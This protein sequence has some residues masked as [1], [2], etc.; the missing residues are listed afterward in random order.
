MQFEKSADT[1][2]IESRL[3]EAKVGDL[4]TYDELSRILGRDVREFAYGALTSARK[5][6]LASGVVFGTESKVGIKRLDDLQIINS[7]ES[8]RKRLQ[9]IGKHSLR[10]LSAVKF[11]NLTEESKR[12]HTTMAAQMGAIAMFASKSTTARIETN[13][14]PTSETLAIGETLKIFTS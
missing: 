5:A 14:K 6:M 7:T 8:D 2:V 3:K 4:I 11:E 1:K 9:R 13:V 10:K 12:K